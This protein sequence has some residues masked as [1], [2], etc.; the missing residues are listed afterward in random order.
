MSLLYTFLPRYSQYSCLIL[1]FMNNKYPYLLWLAFMTIVLLVNHSTHSSSGDS[2]IR[3][4]LRR[5]IDS[6]PSSPSSPSPSPIR[7]NGNG[8]K[9]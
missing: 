7:F 2:M 5:A 9:L 6:S 4:N 3:L 1:K 8:K